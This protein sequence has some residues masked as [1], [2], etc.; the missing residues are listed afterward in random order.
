MYLGSMHTAYDQAT[1]K[2]YLVSDDGAITDGPAPNPKPSLLQKQLQAK[3]HKAD[4]DSKL[5]AAD[6][7]AF[8]PN[9]G[10]P[11]ASSQND[12]HDPNWLDHYLDAEA[13][14][15]SGIKMKHALG[16][17]AFLLTLFAVAGKR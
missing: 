1:G 7:S 14:K 16:A 10:L 6:A 15:G 5:D 4:L 9:G 17:G 8:L 3:Q 13:F 11:N 12:P 2:Y